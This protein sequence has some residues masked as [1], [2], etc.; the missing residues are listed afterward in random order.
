ML[1][2]IN[3]PIID[4]WLLRIITGISAF[5]LFQIEL[6]IAK[7]FLPHYG[8]SYLVWGACVVFFQAALLAGY[9]FVHGLI[10]RY[11][12]RRYRW[13]HLFLI[14]LPLLFFPGRPLMVASSG[15]S[16]PLALDVFL[17][18]C[19]TIG[20]VFFVLSTVSVASQMWLCASPL[21]SKFNP[22][23][24]Y[25]ISNFGS[26]AALLSYP[27]VFEVYWDLPRQL[28][29]WRVLYFL[30]LGLSI[31]MFQRIRIPATAAPGRETAGELIKFSQKA[32]WFLLGAAGVIIFLAATNII[33]GEIVPAPLLW[34]VP[35]C[36]Y[37][38]SFVLNFREKPWCPS[39]I[40]SHISF[41]LGSAALLF[42]LIERRIFPVTVALILLCGVQFILCMYCQNR[43]FAL[44]PKTDRHLTFFYVIFSLGGFAGGFLTTWVIPL[45]SHSIIEYSAGLVVVAATLALE[46]KEHCFNRRHVLWTIALMIAVVTWPVLFPRYN[47]LGVL[48]IFMLFRFVF[49]L[50]FKQAP[51][52]VLCGLVAMTALAYYPPGWWNEGRVVYARRNYYGIN[53]VVDSDGVRSLYH[54]ETLHGAQYL[55]E[56]KKG[57]LLAYY[58]PQLPG[59]EILAADAFPF[60]RIGLI[61]LGAGTLSGYASARQTADFYE[62]DPDVHLIASRYFTYLRDS[63]ARINFIIGDARR[64]LEENKITRYDLLV[65]DAFGG[66]T[67]PFHL[68]T[69]EGVAL[70]RRHLNS[71]GILLFH[72][73]NRYLDLKNVLARVGV[74]LGAHVGFK[75]G[76]QRSFV[77]IVSTWVVMTWD[78]DH[79]Q[80][81]RSRFQWVEP[82]PKV[83][84][85]T[86]L[87]TDQYINIL[88][89]VRL[90]RLLDP[91]KY[92]APFYW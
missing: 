55:A 25:S 59:G 88:P 80:T 63:P 26:F 20:P 11:G 30:M 19:L 5:L 58:S 35:L 41:L 27:F 49:H 10:Q 84:E 90:D 60:E 9:F 86:R 53:R 73:S 46:G 34:V 79:F 87:W 81:L 65:V 16:L 14:L 39:W 52:A 42:F 48:M 83:V 70:Y 32:R 66:D 72:I 89:V 1:R 85:K 64:S 22:Y 23:A 61:G 54:G 57:E 68:L 45:V 62:L 56:D 31:W 82:D 75:T 3:A 29:S 17:R 40:V 37:L 38:L 44:R 18:L 24:L 50:I 12:M 43:L 91:V 6:I 67:V 78:E 7:I 15:Y 77:D 71:G 4:L 28:W 51:V 69:R 92:F 8:G 76:V 21:S 33:T 13:A 2:A 47:F 74:S 36:L